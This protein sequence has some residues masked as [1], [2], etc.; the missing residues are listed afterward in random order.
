MLLALRNLAAEG[1]VRAFRAYKKYLAKYEPQETRSNLGFLVVPA[2][3]TPEEFMAEAEKKNAEA[4]AR[5]AAR[6]RK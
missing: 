2:E 1:N 6:S 3:M 4:D 5:H